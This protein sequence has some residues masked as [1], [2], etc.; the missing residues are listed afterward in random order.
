MSGSKIKNSFINS[1]NE[2]NFIINLKFNDDS[3]GTINYFADGS[4]Q[5]PK[6]KLDI[7]V[8]G[9]ILHLDNFKKL[10]GY[11][12]KNFKKMTSFV[13]DKGQE[14]CIKSFKEAILNNEKSPI[15][16]EELLEVAKI[17]LNLSTEL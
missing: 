12:W 9:K 15:S 14:N 10:N 17:S 5:Y 1:Y 7:F 11:G 13:Q 3:I 6:E 4:M 8:G 16:F 2:E